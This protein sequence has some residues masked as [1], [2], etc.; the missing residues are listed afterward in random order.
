[1]KKKWI[2][3]PFATILLLT[4]CSFGQ[5]V[6]DQVATLLNEM[7]DAEEKYVEAQKSLAELEEAEQASFEETLTL[8]R[9]EK[10]LLQ[11]QVEDL[12][13]SL[14]KRLETLS[15]EKKSMDE[16]KIILTKM[17]E[18]E[19]NADSPM[20]E[21][22]QSLQNALF[23]RYESHALM[24]E[25]YKQLTGKQLELYEALHNESIDFI[26]M[27]AILEEVNALRQHVEERITHFNEKTQETN[28]LKNDFFNSVK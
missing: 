17:D 5:S 8:S 28:Q 7:K 2:W 18:L 6:E 11:Q 10:D 3:V 21:R 22:I 16:S 13:A 24:V 20:K 4:G 19:K 25:G 27:E 12:T 23:E 15:E 1:M 14:E 9:E 26:Q